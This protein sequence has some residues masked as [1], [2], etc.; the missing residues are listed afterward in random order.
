MTLIRLQYGTRIEECDTDTD[1]FTYPQIISVMIHMVARFGPGTASAVWTMDEGTWRVVKG[2]A[3]RRNM[4]TESAGYP[5]FMG[6]PV[7][8]HIPLLK[9][10]RRPLNSPLQT[11]A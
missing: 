3:E 8:V 11:P 2:Q 4:R 1:G 5:W 10:T 6:C 7:R 9:P